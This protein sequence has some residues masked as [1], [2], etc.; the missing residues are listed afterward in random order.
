MTYRVLWLSALV[1]AAFS[2]S[3]FADVYRVDLEASGQADGSDWTHAFTQ[4]QD[5][6]AA[7][8]AGD[9][10]WIAAGVYR[11][12]W[13]GGDRAASFVVPTD[14]ALIPEWS[15]DLRAWYRDGQGPQPLPLPVTVADDNPGADWQVRQ[16]TLDT[17]G[18]GSHSYIRLRAERTP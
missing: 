18:V 12:A 14:V 2:G 16:V 10:V 17:D 7:A 9:A 5:A 11:P 15:P 13:P 1:A 3:L 4:L 8:N 6:L